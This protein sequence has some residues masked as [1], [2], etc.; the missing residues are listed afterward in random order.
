[1]PLE[2]NNTALSIKNYLQNNY[3][4]RLKSDQISKDGVLVGWKITVYDA[5]NAVVTDV[6]KQYLVEAMRAIFVEIVGQSELDTF[7]DT[8]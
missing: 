6:S 4:V 3:A 5:N 8:L 1:M 7:E 2:D